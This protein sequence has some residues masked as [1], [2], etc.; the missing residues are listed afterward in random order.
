M[1]VRVLYLFLWAKNKALKLR[2]VKSRHADTLY[3]TYSADYVKRHPSTITGPFSK[4]ES[5]HTNALNLNCSSLTFNSAFIV[6]VIKSFDETLWKSEGITFFYV[7]P[8]VLGIFS[9]SGKM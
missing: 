1:C 9:L 4:I 6:A 8:K 5:P 7:R 2:Q 3:L